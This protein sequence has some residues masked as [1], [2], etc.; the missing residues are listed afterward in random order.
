M[1]FWKD[2][3][4]WGFI[5]ALISFIWSMVNMYIGKQV[6]DKIMNNDLKHL[7]ADVKRLDKE[8]KEY[9]DELKDELHKIFLRLGKIERNQVRRDA[10]CDERHKQD[11]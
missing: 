5:L 7:E 3:K 4:F 8:N 11:K 2:W 6:A 9:K 10:I 1:E